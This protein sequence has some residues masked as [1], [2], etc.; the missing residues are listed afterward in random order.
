[1]ELKS[2]DC[3]IWNWDEWVEFCHEQEIDP[4]EE[5]SLGFDLGGGDSFTVDYKGDY[6]KKE[7]DE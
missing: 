5:S 6:P 7:E 2:K 4:Y 3:A 1:M